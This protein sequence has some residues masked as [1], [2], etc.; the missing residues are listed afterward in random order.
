MVLI[1]FKVW[2]NWPPSRR[3]PVSREESPASLCAGTLPFEQMGVNVGNQES[4]MYM[5]SA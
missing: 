3:I 2:P 5:S 1:L 4:P